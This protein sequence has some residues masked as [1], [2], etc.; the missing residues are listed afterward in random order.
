MNKRMY[1]IVVGVVAAT[2]LLTMLFSAALENHR[3]AIISL[4][5]EPD[6]VPPRGTCQIVCNATDPDDD[7]LSYG[8]SAGGGTISGKGPVVT[9][10]A[11][12]SAG[13]YNVTVIALDSRGGAVTAN[14]TITVKRNNVPT[15]SSLVASANWTLPA[16]SL[17]V[18]CNASDADGDKLSYEWSAD[19][20][21]VSGT[22]SKVTWSAPQTV[23]TYNI[24][25][26]VSDGHGGSVT[27]T[28]P[29]S[30]ALEQPP[31]IE[32]LRVTKDRYGHCFLKAYSWGYKVGQGKKYDI[33]CVVANTSGEV[34]YEWSWEDGEVS[35]G[36][37][38]I[39]WTAPNTSDEVTV[40]V[41]VSDSAG[42]RGAM[43]VILEVVSCNSCTFP[44]CA[45]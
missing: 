39:T 30:V 18:T 2:V 20:G 15:I 1:L 4:K 38:M 42:N 19:G 25:V 3:P 34:S 32:A 12:G 5:A 35:G 33:E 7:E 37:S 40:T 36:G 17:N 22:G 43:N 11:P 10:T 8:W 44:G 27:R 16:V 45:G 9:W 31:I 26:V 28:L 21:D 24:T 14:V 29:I 13:S 23:G 41:T 6:R